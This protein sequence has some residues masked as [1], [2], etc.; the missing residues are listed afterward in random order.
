MM[1]SLKNIVKIVKKIGQ[2]TINSVSGRGGG[3]S[4][5]IP[6]TLYNGLV[7]SGAAEISEGFNTF[8]SSIGP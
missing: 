6:N 5:N 2:T 8:F 3:K 4:I 1:T 7:L